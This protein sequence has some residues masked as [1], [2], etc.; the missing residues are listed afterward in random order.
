M[1][2]IGTAD[3]ICSNDADTLLGFFFLLRTGR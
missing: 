3:M 2:E 1:R